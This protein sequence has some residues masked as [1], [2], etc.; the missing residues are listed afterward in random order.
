MAPETGSLIVALATP[1]GRGALALVR[2]SGQG[3]LD[4]ARRLSG[5]P[6]FRPRVATH[7][8]LRLPGDLTDSA[9][10]TTCV[11][12][13]SFTGE[14]AV[15]ITTHGS[16]VIVD[17]VLQACLEAGA[18]L[19]RPGEF[20][21]RAY[22]HGRLDL[23][24]AEAVADLVAATTPAQVRV[25]SSH[26]DGTLSESIRA[27]GD[28]IAALR[29]LLEAS[30]DFPDEGFHFIA[31]EAVVG[32][33]RILQQTCVRLLG[34]ASAGRRLH[35]G[36]L[37]V[38]AGRPNAGKSSVFNALLGRSRAIVGPTAGTTRDLLTESIALG[39]VPV[40]L[41]D[42]AGLRDTDDHVEREGVARAE[43]SMAAADLVIVVVDPSAGVD[44]LEEGRSLWQSLDG[45][46]RVCVLNKVDV[47]G[48]SAAA[49]PVWAPP[50]AIPVSATEGTGIDRL[51]EALAGVLG[52]VTWEGETLT[53]ARH[54]SLV[55]ECA[56]ALAR[57]EETAT[58][59][60][61]EEY[62]LADLG[63]ALRA[64]SDLRGVESAED[65]LET[66]FATFCIGK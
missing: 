33:L 42:T 24:Q 4:V 46:G 11:A 14:D 45:R 40:T 10:I 43:Q 20:T 28:E 47:W 9:V 34:T 38:V 48:A 5:R 2:L 21:Y 63:D 37:V 56:A 19:A 58:A 6:V 23:L 13:H 54:R 61:S 51:G 32:R 50:D 36:A 41:A 64:L 29:A 1:P 65:V 26:L 15:E 57:A 52:R 60:G 30:L 27:M 25:A 8:R 66:I 44:A 12:P 17:A 31:P 62:V 16:P 55:G 53:R 49:R 22:L 39:G 3:A 7:T 35:D 18:R 59:G